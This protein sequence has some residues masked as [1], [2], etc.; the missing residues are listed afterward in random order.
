MRRGSQGPWL[1]ACGWGVDGKTISDS[2]NIIRFFE[3]KTEPALDQSLTK[4]ECA[5]RILLTRLMNGS[6]YQL[7]VAGRWLDPEV[8]PRFV[9]SFRTVLPS[10]MRALWPLAIGDL[11]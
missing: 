10:S 1:R 6:I 2:E 3:S 9:E 5:Q 7:M 8:Y 4:A 11:P